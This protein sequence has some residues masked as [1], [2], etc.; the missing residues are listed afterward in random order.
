[1]VLTPDRLRRPAL[2]TF[3]LGLAACNAG[4]EGGSGAT[5][6]PPTQGDPTGGTDDGATVGTGS[7]S[8]S[9]TGSHDTE[10]GPDAGSGGP[11]DGDSTTGSNTAGSSGDTTGGMVPT[12]GGDP[13]TAGTTGGEGADYAADIQLTLVEA[14]QGVSIPLGDEGTLNPLDQRMAELHAGRRTAVRAHYTVDPSFVPREIE[15]VLTLEGGGP[16]LRLRD[17]QA[18]EDDSNFRS[19]ESTFTWWVEP[20]QLQGGTRFSV[21][22]HEVGNAAGAPASPSNRLPLEGTADMGVR[23]GEMELNIVMI[24]GHINGT[25]ITITNR[26]RREV[27][28]YLMAATPVQ[29]VSVSWRQPEVRGSRFTDVD[30]AWDLIDEIRAQDDLG[31]NVY[32]HLFLADG[33]CDEDVFWFDGVGGI[34]GETQDPWDTNSRRAL[35]ITNGNVDDKMDIMIHELGHN[36]G[37]PHAACGTQGYDPD[38]PTYGDYAEAGIGVQG[39]NI[40]TDELYD[41]WVENEG[42][43]NRP[44]KDFMSYCWPSWYSDYNWNLVAERVAT[45]TAW[46]YTDAPDRRPTRMLRGIRNPNGTVKR[47]AVVPGSTGAPAGLDDLQTAPSPQN[48]GAVVTAQDGSTVL[49]AVHTVPLSHDGYE[50]LFVPLP[51]GVDP[52]AARVITPDR[53]YD[54]G[55]SQLVDISGR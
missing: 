18:V 38:Y 41:P 22:L 28:D 31:P 26:G 15:G 9:G 4:T 46:D 36:Q 32:Y 37:L 43:G 16:P 23:S 6:S 34:A 48:P 35:T 52:V 5:G 17:V 24:P 7:G 50:V 30:D 39:L 14:N 11:G 10:A 54:I 8:G 13:T 29:D 49:R 25:E 42:P 19:L 20:E 55:P 12:T 21:S 2:F 45:V 53:A 51:D 40:T 44:Y 33:C 1:M 47:W 3:S 27:E